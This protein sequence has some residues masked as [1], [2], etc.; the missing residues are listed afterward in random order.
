MMILAHSFGATSMRLSDLQ[1]A[2]P[3]MSQKMLIQQLR[4]LERDGVL[5]RTAYAQVP[6]Q[7]DYDFIALGRKLG[8]VFLALLDWT[9]L[10][11]STRTE[12]STDHPLSSPA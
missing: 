4:A 1:R 12:S 9:R 8:S 3:A 10:R 2:T 11:H 5:S 7:V 6:P